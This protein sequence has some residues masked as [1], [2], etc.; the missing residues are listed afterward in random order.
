MKH[1]HLGMIDVKYKIGKH[2]PTKRIFLNDPML[3][4]QPYFDKRFKVC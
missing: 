1:C 3:N 4:N 2:T